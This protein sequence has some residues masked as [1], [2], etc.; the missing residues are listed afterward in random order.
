MWW[1]WHE[2]LGVENVVKTKEVNVGLVYNANTG[3]GDGIK[4]SVVIRER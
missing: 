2:T 4:V 3:K 1:Q